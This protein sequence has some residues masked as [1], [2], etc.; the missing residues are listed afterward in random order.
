MESTLF[1]EISKLVAHLVDE[2]ERAVVVL[3]G[4][5]DDP[6]ALAEQPHGHARADLVCV[7]EVEEADG[8]R[9]SAEEVS[10]ESSQLRTLRYLRGVLSSR[11][12]HH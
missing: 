5:A 3:Y 2:T 10:A 8:Q 11:S 7:L 12:R 4:E 6:L 1:T 9:V